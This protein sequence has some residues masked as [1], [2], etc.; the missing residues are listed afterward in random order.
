MRVNLYRQ[1]QPENGKGQLGF[2]LN[3]FSGCLITSKAIIGSLKIIS[4]HDGQA[5]FR[6]PHHRAICWATLAKPLSKL[7]SIAA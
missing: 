3:G 2:A 1:R 6:L 5:V 4:H 7:L